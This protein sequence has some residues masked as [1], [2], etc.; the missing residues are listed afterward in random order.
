M[1]RKTA[2]LLHTNHACAVV[3]VMT[4]AR[5][6]FFDWRYIRHATRPAAAVSYRHLKKQ[7]KKKVISYFFTFIIIRKTKPGSAPDTCA[8]EF[9]IRFKLL[10]DLQKLLLSYQVEFIGL[11]SCKHLEFSRNTCE[12]DTTLGH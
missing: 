4:H 9:R 12:T 7:N 2:G 3:C 1:N 5:L 11:L 8:R 6:F 10:G